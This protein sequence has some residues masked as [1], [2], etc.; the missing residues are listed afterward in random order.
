MGTSL[1]LFS[2]I[3]HRPKQTACHWEVQKMRLVQPGPVGLIFEQ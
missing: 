2:S 1:I 3:A